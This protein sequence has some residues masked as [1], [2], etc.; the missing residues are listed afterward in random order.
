MNHHLLMRAMTMISPLK[1]FK[2]LSVLLCMGSNSVSSFR[3]HPNLRISTRVVTTSSSIEPK[4]EPEEALLP[5]FNAQTSQG[6]RLPLQTPHSHYHWKG[7]RMK[8]RFFEG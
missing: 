7:G 8:R 6:E 4:I 1:R 2:L 5:P 3:F